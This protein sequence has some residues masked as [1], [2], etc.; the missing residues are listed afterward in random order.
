MSFYTLSQLANNYF[1]FKKFRINQEGSAMKVCT[2]SC[3]FGAWIKEPGAQKILDIGTGTGLLSLMI[4]QTHSASI[5]AVEINETSFMQ[6]KENFQ[7]SPWKNQISVFH[8]DINHFIPHHGVLYDLIVCNPPFFKNHFKSSNPKR[9]EVL[10]DELLSLENLI[11]RI[12]KLIKSSG[13]FYIMLPFWQA[14]HFKKLAEKENFYPVKQLNVKEKEEK[15]IIRTF[16]A[17]S[18]NKKNAVGESELII[19]N[20]EN[21]Y[22]NE[23]AMLLKE[24]YLH[25]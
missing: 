6:A 5:D 9:N 18:S 17:Y 24:F 23:F 21:T 2:D 10:H 16:I 4:A 7:N 13:I 15:E 14:I 19:K 12:K 11:H 8:E 25:L 22:T 1:Q 20:A 3:I